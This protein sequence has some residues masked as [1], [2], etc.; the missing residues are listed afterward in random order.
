MKKRFLVLFLL[1]FSIANAQKTVTVKKGEI[2]LNGEKIAGFDGKGGNAFRFGNYSISIEGIDTPVITIKEDN[3]SFLNP[4]YEDN[5]YYFEIRFAS[6]QT[7]YYRAKP[8][9]KKFFGNV[10]TVYPRITGN[11]IIEAIFNDTVPQIITN[12]SLNQQNITSL[13]ENYG[14]PKIKV[15]AEIKAVEDSIGMINSVKI[16]RD[17]KS[18]I[19]FKQVTVPGADLGKWYNIIQDNAVI[20]RLYKNIG[21]EAIYQIWKKSPQEFTLL[22]RKMEFAPLVITV[23]LTK[24]NHMT[25]TY[26]CIKVSG[27]ERIAFKTNDYTNA[28]N[29]LANTLINLGLL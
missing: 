23:S 17:V 29:D 13:F 3:L 6:G 15:M 7:Y 27:K 1:G 19:A 28:E 16:N 25:K 20:G 26:E 21:N 5:Q 22:G 9:T 2:K 24:G 4:F 12:K 18:P 10:V 11:D 14:Y 8:E